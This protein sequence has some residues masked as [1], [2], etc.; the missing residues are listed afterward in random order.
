MAAFSYALCL[1]TALA[2]AG[3]LFRAYRRQPASLLFWA[4]CCF[5]GLSLANALVVLDLL[6]VPDRDLY[7]LRLAVSLASISLLVFGMVWD[8]D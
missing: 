2:C 5:C 8:A 1:S 6:V 4:A 3:L 7:P